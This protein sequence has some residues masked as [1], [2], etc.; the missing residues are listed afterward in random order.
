MLCP[1]CKTII[2][3]M[4]ERFFD[5]DDGETLIGQEHYRCPRC[6]STFSRDVTYSLVGE[7]E[8]EE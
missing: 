4:Y 2:M 5:Y 1:K 6:Q 8:L 7:G 3:E